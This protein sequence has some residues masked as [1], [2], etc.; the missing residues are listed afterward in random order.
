MRDFRVRPAKPKDK[1]TGR[2]C[3]DPNCNGDLRRTTV[4]FGEDLREEYLD[5]GFNHG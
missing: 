5:R 3:E 2:K 4:A 1:R